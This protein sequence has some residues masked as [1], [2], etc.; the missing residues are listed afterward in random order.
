MMQ[1]SP[2]VDCLQDLSDRMAEQL[3]NYHTITAHGENANRAT[4]VG[5]LSFSLLPD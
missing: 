1:A 3:P 4:G 2:F 5:D